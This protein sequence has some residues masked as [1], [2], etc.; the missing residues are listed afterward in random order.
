VRLIIL[1]NLFMLML[2]VFSTVHVPSWPI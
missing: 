1:I 2:T